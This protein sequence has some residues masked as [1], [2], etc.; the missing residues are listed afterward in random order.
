M[1][2]GNGCGGYR[3]EQ[4]AV[5]DWRGR[6]GFVGGRK[7]VGR[8]KIFADSLQSKTIN[9]PAR[10]LLLRIPDQRRIVRETLVLFEI[11]ILGILKTRDVAIEKN[12]LCAFTVQGGVDVVL[13]RNRR[14][15]AVVEK[16]D[17]GSRLSDESQFDLI[18]GT[19]PVDVFIE[20][21]VEQIIAIAPARIGR[22]YPD[23]I[24][25]IDVLVGAPR[26][27]A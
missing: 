21:V 19:Q 22:A 12:K 17:G 4:G 25:R 23:R 16:P 8:W 5:A 11:P 13:L 7:S 18:A 6:F 3:A 15:P 10:E 14:K 1:G 2:A 26:I 27:S 9:R 20:T 24:S